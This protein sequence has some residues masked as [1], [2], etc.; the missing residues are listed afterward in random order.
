MKYFLGGQSRIQQIGL[1]ARLKPRPFKTKY[2][3]RSL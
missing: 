3:F 1:S 2:F